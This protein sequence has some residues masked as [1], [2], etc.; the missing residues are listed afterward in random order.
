M[1]DSGAI[2]A[3]FF[4]DP[5]SESVE[6][7]IYKYESFHTVDFALAE[8][9]NVAWKRVKIFGEDINTCTKALSLARDFVE[10]ACQVTESRELMRQALEIAVEENIN[11]YDSLFLALAKRAR[12]KLLT[13]DRPLHRKLL[14]SKKVSGITI[15]PS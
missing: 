8:V 6:T 5:Y 9:C 13:T 14:D 3:L 4:N 7:A 1:L 11:A 12:S 15:L 10:N 2:A